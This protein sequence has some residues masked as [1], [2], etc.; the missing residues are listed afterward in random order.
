MVA[1]SAWSLLLERIGRA[2][3]GIADQL[4]ALAPRSWMLLVLAALLGLAG[5]AVPDALVKGPVFAG[6]G[7]LLALALVIRLFGRASRSARRR[8]EAALATLLDINDDDEG[9]SRS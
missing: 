5:L 9:S 6:A 8:Q 4:R 1:S 7:T 3:A 2:T